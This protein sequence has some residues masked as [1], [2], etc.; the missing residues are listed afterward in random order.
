VLRFPPHISCSRLPEFSL[1]EF[2]DHES[3]PHH[4][5]SSR[6]RCARILYLRCYARA[7]HSNGTWMR[8]LLVRDFPFFRNSDFPAAVGECG[9][10]RGNPGSSEGENA[11]NRV[12]LFGGGFRKP[13]IRKSGIYQSVISSPF[14][15]LPYSFYRNQFSLIERSIGSSSNQGS[16]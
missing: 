11:L 3:R 13:E 6:N 1:A 14:N 4:S 8:L 7:H 16:T 12:D 15:R 10:E 5:N 9:D 2:F